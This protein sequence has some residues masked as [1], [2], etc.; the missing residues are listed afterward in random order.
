[1]NVNTYEVNQSE[2]GNSASPVMIS[3]SAPMTSPTFYLV[4]KQV[5]RAMKYILRLSR[6]IGFLA[7]CGR[8]HFTADQY[9][10]LAGAIHTSYN[11]SANICT[12][13][14]ICGAQLRFMLSNFFP[15]SKLYY[16][17]NNHLRLNRR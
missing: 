3:A 17:K 7:V 15:R 4:K 10:F 13:K 11:G 6:M 1:M 9:H 12:Y 16:I 14:S 2:H 5:K 8:V